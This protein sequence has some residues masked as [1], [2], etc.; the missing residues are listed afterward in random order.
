MQDFPSGVACAPQN[1]GN[2]SH[3]PVMSDLRAPSIGRSRAQ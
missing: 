1:E 3:D 2:Q